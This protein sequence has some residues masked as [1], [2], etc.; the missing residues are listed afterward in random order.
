M[1][2]KPK[3]SVII[4]YFNHERFLKDAL[5]SAVAQEFLPCEV[6]VVDDGSTENP[7]EII[8]ET[9]R[10]ASV[11]IRYV[12]LN[13]HRGVSAAR[14]AGI[15]EARG[16]YVA[17]LDADD[18]WSSKH[19]SHFLHVW[20]RVKETEYYSAHA[21]FFTDRC[22]S[23]LH[24]HPRWTKGDYVKMA[25]R[26][27]SLVN[28]SSVILSRALVEKTGLFDERLKV[29]EDMDYW[30]RAGKHAPLVYNK[31]TTAFIRKRPDS[32]SQRL[33]LYK[34]DYLKEWFE[35][36]LKGPLSEEQRKWF[37]LNIYGTIMRFRKAGEKEPG[38]L[39]EMLNKKYLSVRQRIFLN[40]PFF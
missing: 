8:R 9:N 24:A 26:N 19:L 35:K 32:L 34:E 25:L 12:A 5:Y 33:D 1:S 31:I 13:T 39:R 23:L 14:N 16:D 20:S 37:H 2:N 10:D 27:P 17:F 36:I 29:F 15:K 3:I 30:W 40:I 6:I 7:E 11:P 22:P 38:V 21:R 4:P 28:A 18:C